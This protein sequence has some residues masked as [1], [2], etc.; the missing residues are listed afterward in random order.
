MRIFIASLVVLSVLYIWDDR[1][2]NGTLWDGLRS[3]GRS[4]AHNMAP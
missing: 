3:M 4:I 1:Y 2:N